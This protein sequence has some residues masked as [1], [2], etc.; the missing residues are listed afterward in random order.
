MM[1]DKR[2]D[3][4]VPYPM[5]VPQNDLRLAVDSDCHKHDSG[6]GADFIVALAYMVARTSVGALSSAGNVSEVG[7]TRSYISCMGYGS[8]RQSCFL[9]L[10]L[11][12]NPRIDTLR[13]M[14]RWHHAN[15]HVCHKTPHA[16][17]HASQ[18]FCRCA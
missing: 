2:I 5:P 13:D 4:V 18:R 3:D 10:T 9:G 12:L 14:E 15:E 17:R 11:C 6:T 1:K 7:G 8:D 16:T